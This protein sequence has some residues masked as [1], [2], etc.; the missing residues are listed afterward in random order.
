MLR[1]SL[2]GLGGDELLEK[3]GI[4][5]RLR[6]EVIGVADFVKLANLI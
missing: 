5:G 3:A 4:D 2:K 1:A 6:A